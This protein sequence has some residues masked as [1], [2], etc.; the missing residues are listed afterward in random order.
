MEISSM[1][2]LAKKAAMYVLPINLLNTKGFFPLPIGFALP[3]S[4]LAVAVEP[5]SGDLDIRCVYL[6]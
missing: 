3:S 5:G 6:S 2:Y 4:P 1:F